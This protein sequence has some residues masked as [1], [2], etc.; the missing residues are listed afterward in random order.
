MQL[1]QYYSQ[2]IQKMDFL[3]LFVCMFYE[4]S[5]TLTTSL[6][7]LRIWD[8]AVPLFS[9]KIGQT[10][11]LSSRPINSCRRLSAVKCMLYKHLSFFSHRRLE[12]LHS[13][14]CRWTFEGGGVAEE[15][16]DRLLSLIE[17]LNREEMTINL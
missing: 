1:N 15:I 4:S 10:N 9:T 16:A 8:K 12:I 17:F 13:V 5:S 2:S 6:T 11:K 14:T 3:L 7:R